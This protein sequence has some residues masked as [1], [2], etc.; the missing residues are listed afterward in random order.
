M[1][2]QIVLDLGLS[3]TADRKL[4]SHGLSPRDAEEVL[5]DSPR[6]MWADQEDRR[7]GGDPVP[8]QPRRIRMI[9]WNKRRQML[10]VILDPPDG[11]GRSLVITGYP[12][13]RRD[14]ER[15]RQAGRRSER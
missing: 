2:K 14:R 13:G 1:P 8:E 10:T 4:L 6:F 9:G 7:R 3:P 15:Y 11:E 5:D 12:S